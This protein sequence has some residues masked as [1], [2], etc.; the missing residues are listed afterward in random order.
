M[1]VRDLVVRHVAV[2]AVLGMTLGGRTVAAQELAGDPAARLSAVLPAAVAQHLLSLL[3]TARAEGLPADALA[4]R[5][6]KFAAR[7]IAPDA[8]ARAADDQLVRLRDARDVLRRARSTPPHSDEIEAGAESLREGVTGADIAKL[9]QSAP[10]G[11]SL[12]V[13]LYVIGSLVSTGIAS[14]DALRRVQARLEAHA[15]D[16]D[17]E[18]AGRGAAVSHRPTD[19]G[20]GHGAG[21]GQ[22]GGV[23]A[24]AHGGGPPAGVP[25]NAGQHGKPTTP[26]GQSNR[27]PGKGHP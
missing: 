3:R 17:I 18:A 12:A 1:R 7:G 4:N 16:S 11:R 13:P 20:R 27:P 23:G 22:S 14:S 6:L 25:G 24:P 19:A 2:V 10:S 8:I 5:S 15:S 9:A 21:R 26:P